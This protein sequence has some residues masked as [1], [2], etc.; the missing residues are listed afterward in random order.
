MTIHLQYSL[1][2]REHIQQFIYKTISL[3]DL[4]ESMKTLLMLVYESK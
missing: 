1:L 4:P 2:E 3:T